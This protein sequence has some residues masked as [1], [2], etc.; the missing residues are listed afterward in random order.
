MANRNSSGSNEPKLSP[1]DHKDTKL[2]D[3]QKFESW[4]MRLKT[5]LSKANGRL[6]VVSGTLLILCMPISVGV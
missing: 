5:R 3:K 4:S 6:P 1:F 2:S